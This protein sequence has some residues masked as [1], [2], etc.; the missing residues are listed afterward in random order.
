MARSRKNQ[1]IVIKT[2]DD[3]RRFNEMIMDKWREDHGLPPLKRSKG[4][5]HAR[6]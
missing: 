4:K 6:K 2:D 3:M 5:R 1:T